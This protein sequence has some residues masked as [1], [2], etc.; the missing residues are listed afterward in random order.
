[1]SILDSF[2]AFRQAVDASPE[3]VAVARERRRAFEQALL[4]ESDVVEVIASGSL[5]RGTHK[6][7]IHDVD[8]V[9]VFD[10]DEHPD[11]DHAGS[12]AAEALAHT[13]DA[14]HRLLGATDGTHDQLVRLALP[15]NHAVKCFLDDPDDEDAFTVDVMPAFRQAGGIRI[16]EALSN[17]WV[18]SNP[19][20]LIGLSRGKHSEWNKWAGSVRMLKRWGSDRPFKVKS[21]VMEVLALDHLPTHLNNQPS[22]LQAFFTAAAYAVESGQPI[23]DPAGLCGP[24]QLDLDAVALGEELRQAAS[25]AQAALAAQIDN[26]KALASQ[27]WADVFGSDFPVIAAV[28]GVTTTTSPR[29]VKDSPQG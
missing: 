13:R 10:R 7:P 15:R 22:A 17:E 6:A 2:A 5:A 16:P 4:S 28:G 1:M 19:E 11:W 23:E 12:S 24:I 8:L 29:P 18:D 14:V 9:I 20:L 27:K 25:D 3:Q 26:N 21:L